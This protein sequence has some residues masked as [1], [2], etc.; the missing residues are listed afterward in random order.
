MCGRMNV[1]DHPYII[2]LMDIIGMPL[3]PDK[4]VNIAPG[5]YAQFIIEQSGQRKLLDGMWSL[6]IEPKPE[7]EGFRPSPKWKT[8]NARADRLNSSPL[9]K[10]RFSRQRAIVPVRGFH[11]WLGKQCFQITG[12]DQALALAGLYELWQFGE[13][14]VPS[15]TIITLGPHP[16]FSAIH[17]KSIPLILTPKDFD[18]WLDPDLTDTDVFVDL[19]QTHLSVTLEAI[20]VKSPQSLEPTG[21]PIEIPED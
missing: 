19:M 6:L 8:F 13:F 5:A 18:A 2:L 12:K 11:E 15:F 1:I 16:R 3:Y 7:G 20:P 17:D 14:L 4:R 9:W 21:A 10:K